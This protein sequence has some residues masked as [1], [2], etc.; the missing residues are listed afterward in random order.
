MTAMPT[1]VLR[2]SCHISVDSLNTSVIAG[3]VLKPIDSRKKM[4]MTLAATGDQAAAK[5]RR[6]ALSS[7]EHKALTP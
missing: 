3:W 4:A 6:L 7:A 2:P 5:K 1:V